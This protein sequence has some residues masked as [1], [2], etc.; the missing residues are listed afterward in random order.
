MA[1][2]FT[3]FTARV[4]LLLEKFKTS[5]DV[6]RYKVPVETLDKSRDCGLKTRGVAEVKASLENLVKATQGIRS[7]L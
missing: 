1:L 3:I 2:V 5:F 6:S 4:S 7:E